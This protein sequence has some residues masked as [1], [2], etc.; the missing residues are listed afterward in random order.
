M[1]NGISVKINVNVISKTISYG[2]ND[3]TL[4]TSSKLMNKH[5]MER[6]ASTSA[7]A[8]IEDRLSKQITPRTQI[9]NESKIT[10][11]A[12]KQWLTKYDFNDQ[13][14]ALIFCNSYYATPNDL[15]DCA[16]NDGLLARQEFERLGYH[17]IV[18]YDVLSNT[19]ID[20]TKRFLSQKCKN[21][22]IYFIGHGAYQTQH[23]TTISKQVQ[24]ID[25]NDK[26]DECFVFK[27]K[28]VVDDVISKTI[29]EN[30]TCKR[31]WLIA[32]ACHSGTIYDIP[33]RD[34]IITIS[35]CLDSQTSKQDYFNRK[36]NGVFSYY[37]WKTLSELQASDSKSTSNADS[38]S[39]SNVDPTSS[40]TKLIDKI[41][42]KL[43]VYG[44]KCNLNYVPN[45]LFI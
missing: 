20:Q 18:Y 36:G 4:S 22:A 9:L 24:N 23:P 35:S 26:R 32:D 17:A 10:I 11:D 7:S 13:N 33:S 8:S 30:N 28:F 21:L 42:L 14:V 6:A 44:Q 27:D 38:K 15:G 16:I 43:A 12:A 40:T 31:L 41:N 1:G 3:G 25:S 2:N 39:T 45:K 29:L 37:F 34:D 19:F 5:Q